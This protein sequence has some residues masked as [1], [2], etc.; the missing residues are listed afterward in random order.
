MNANRD[1]RTQ[2]S[3]KAQR[4]ML[5]DRDAA[6]SYHT[7]CDICRSPARTT[8]AGMLL[9]RECLDAARPHRDDDDAYDDI[10][11]GD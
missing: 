8:R 6:G 4:A 9:C 5:W 3:G 1:M 11:A 10:A 7:R 2:T